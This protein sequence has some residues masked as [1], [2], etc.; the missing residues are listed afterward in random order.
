MLPEYVARYDS[1]DNGFHGADLAEKRQ[2]E[3]HARTP[4]MNAESIRGL[5]GDRF[6]VQSE[7]DP[8]RTYLVDLSNQSC[9]CLDWPRVELCKHVTAVAHFFGHND[10]QMGAV[11]DTVPKMALPT[12]EGSP[13][14]CS[15][16]SSDAS[17]ATASILEN[18]ITVS[19]EFLNDGVPLS[20]GTI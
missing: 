15:D 16:V 5:G 13:D 17:A 19:R 10:Q 14:V 8:S 1:Q 6:R 7:T 20:P 11:E 4:E 3:I 18:V 2:K 9:D 12:W